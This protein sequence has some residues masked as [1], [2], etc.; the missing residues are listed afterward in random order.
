MEETTFRDV[1]FAVLT[2]IIFLG[3]GALIGIVI[4]A[5]KGG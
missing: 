1:L 2:N 5:A 3:G 4:C